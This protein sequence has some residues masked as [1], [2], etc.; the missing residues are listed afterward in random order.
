[1]PLKDYLKNNYKK[2]ASSIALSDTSF[3]KSACVDVCFN[4][5]YE[6]KESKSEIFVLFD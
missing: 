2:V 5:I 1:M 3:K 6:A 4:S